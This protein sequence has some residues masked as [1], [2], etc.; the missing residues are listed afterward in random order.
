MDDD[1]TWDKL[2]KS[3]MFNLNK[4]KSQDIK[5]LKLSF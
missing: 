3:L 4:K 2:A 5:A 1:L